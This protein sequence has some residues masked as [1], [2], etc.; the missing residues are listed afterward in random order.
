MASGATRKRPDPDGLVKVFRA[1][2]W[3][4]GLIENVHST[5]NDGHVGAFTFGKVTGMTIGVAAGLDIPLGSVTPAKWKHAMLVPGAKD[6]SKARASI[7]FP[8]CTMMWAR[9]GDHGRSEAAIIALYNAIQLGLK[10]KKAFTMGLVNFEKPKPK[11]SH[12]K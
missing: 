1:F 4:S 2:P 12:N 3:D 9:A 11:R 7:I 8:N 10:P 6:E 5:P